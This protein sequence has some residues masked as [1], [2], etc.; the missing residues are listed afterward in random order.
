MYV[1]FPCSDPV[2]AGNWGNIPAG[3][4]Y[5]LN[6]TAFERSTISRDLTAWERK[7]TGKQTFPRESFGTG[8][9]TSW[10]TGT[11]F[12]REREFIPIPVKSCGFPED[13]PDRYDGS[14]SDM[15]YQVP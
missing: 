15:S 7:T 2:H 9:S 14:F 12:A 10:T 8:M 5:S 11:M 3:I 13:C 1:T 4:V 6:A